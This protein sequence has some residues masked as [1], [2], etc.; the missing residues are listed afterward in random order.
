[1]STRVTA[2]VLATL[3]FAPAAHAACPVTVSAVRGAAPLRLSF[4]AGCPSAAY[5][6]SFGDGTAGDGP[7]ATHA[8][9]GG[10]FAPTLSTDSGT[11]RLPVITSVALSLVAPRKAD[12]GER[13]TLHA[14]VV[15]KLPVR[16]GGR[17]F[18]QGRLTVTVT[19]PFLTAVAGPAV[20]R[21]AIVVKPRLDVHLDGARTVGSPLHV[22]AILRPAHA[23]RVRVL[24][25]GL[26][27]ARVETSEVRTA[28]IVVLSKP[29]PSWAPVSKVVRAHIGAPSLA[30]GARG[31]GVVALEQRLRELDYAVRDT[32]G[33][34]D[35]AVEA[36]VVAFQKVNGLERT[37]VV[38]PGIW[39]R[40]ARA[41]IPRARYGGNHVEVDKARQVL[42]LVRDG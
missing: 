34:F 41:G 40:L 26:P 2:A 23:G 9:A 27:S 7:S 16:L 37:G 19:Q 29:R 18:R 36:A 20:V 6:W 15:P 12:Y 33:V 3:A 8:Y 30:L 1:M 10:R 35:D 31:P 32:R 42:F 17:L 13:V 5:R 4:H 22:V 39:D 24:V 14:Q 38:T 25:D 11:Q 21:R 28:R